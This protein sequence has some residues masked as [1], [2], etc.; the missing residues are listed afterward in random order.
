MQFSYSDVKIINPMNL[1]NIFVPEIGPYNHLSY[2]LLYNIQ[3]F[4]RKEI[5]N[6]K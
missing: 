4:Q 3:P 5:K 6:K 2:Y 1:R